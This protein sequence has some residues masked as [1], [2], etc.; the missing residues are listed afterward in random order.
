MVCCEEKRRK[1]RKIDCG[2]NYL[3][4]FGF[5]GVKISKKNVTSKVICVRSCEWICSNLFFFFIAIRLYVLYN[6]IDLKQMTSKNLH[7]SSQYF[8]S[9]VVLYDTE[10]IIFSTANC[11]VKLTTDCFYL[12][13]QEM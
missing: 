5:N 11:T 4:Y 7:R 6:V 13:L 10:V 8:E 9:N 1:N 3:T 2:L 12:N